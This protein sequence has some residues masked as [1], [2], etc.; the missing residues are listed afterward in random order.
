[1]QGENSTVDEGYLAG[2]ETHPR[3][4][5][6]EQVAAMGADER[7]GFEATIVQALESFAA[8]SQP[9]EDAVAARC[10]GADAALAP[11]CDELWDGI[12]IVR[13]RAQHAAL[14]YRAVLAY[15]GGGDGMPLVDRAARVT[16]QAAQVVARREAQYRFD[17]DRVAGN[18][19]NPTIYGFGYLRPAHTQCY[20]RRRE[21]QVAFLLQNGVAEGILSL[22]NCQD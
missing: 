22:P 13:L 11:W 10:R 15:A 17:L 20:W 1:V 19:K 16:D 14:L 9:I 3:R 6:F 8:E 2:L 12:A 7:A 21:E 4:L 18:P 5:A